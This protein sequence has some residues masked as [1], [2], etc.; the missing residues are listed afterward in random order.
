MSKCANK[1]KT[2]LSLIMS[3]YVCKPSVAA[4][5][6]MAVACVVASIVGRFVV[7]FMM[8]AVVVRVVVVMVVVPNVNS[9]SA[10][11]VAPFNLGLEVWP[12][13][14]LITLDGVVRVS[15]SVAEIPG[16]WIGNARVPGYVDVAN[17]KV[18]LESYIIKNID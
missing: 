17:W 16:I 12:F 11:F 6:S 5:V 10:V 18:L 2:C 1:E 14:M 15:S 13:A 8:A 3:K 9:V 4:V 7:C